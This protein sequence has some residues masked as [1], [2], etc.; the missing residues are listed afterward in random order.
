MIFVNMV[1]SLLEFDYGYIMQIR[2][3][4][5]GIKGVL[6]RGKLKSIGIIFLIY[7]EFTPMILIMTTN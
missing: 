4:K 5:T 2:G 1:F 7:A 3:L 6:K